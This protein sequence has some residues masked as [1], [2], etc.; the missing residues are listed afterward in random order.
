MSSSITNDQILT[1]TLLAI[2]IF[3]GLF[4]LY[5]IRRAIINHINY[6]PNKTLKIDLTRKN[7]MDDNDLLDYYLINY[8][9]EKILKHIKTI[10][11]WKSKKISR[12]KSNENKIKKFKLR[13]SKNEYKAFTFIGERTQTRYRQK[14]YVRESYKVSIECNSFYI[15]ENEILERISF[16]EK[17]NYNVTYNNFNKNDQRKAMTKELREQIKIRDNYTCQICGKH[18]PDEVGLHIDHIVA[19]KNGGKSIPENLRVLCSKCN[20]SKG[21]K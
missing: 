19:I 17:N 8:G 2:G 1:Y 9:T 16:L 21:G 18:M 3:F 5:F 11:E 6:Y 13:C 4:I 10:N 7:K 12:Y 15:S 14:N 20:G